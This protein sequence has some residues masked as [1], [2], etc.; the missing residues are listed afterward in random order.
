MGEQIVTILKCLSLLVV[1]SCLSA[2]SLTAQVVK[3][4]ITPTHATNQFVPKQT[5]GAGIDRIQT[6]AIDKLMNKTTLDKVFT[7][8]WQPVTYRQNTELAIEAWHWNPDGA[9]S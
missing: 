7:A 8:G 9:W 6:V 2:L 1:G 3:V 5:L 4:D